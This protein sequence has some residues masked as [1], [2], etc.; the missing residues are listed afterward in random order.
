MDEILKNL[1][2]IKSNYQKTHDKKNY[3]TSI[4]NSIGNIV[5]D[6]KLLSFSSLDKSNFYEKFNDLFKDQRKKRENVIGLEENNKLEK[7]IFLQV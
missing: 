4:K 2:N 1:D 3:L 7:R 6:E 5:N